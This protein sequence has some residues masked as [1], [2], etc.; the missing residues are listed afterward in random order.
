M[1]RT[2][3]GSKYDLRINPIYQVDWQNEASGKRVSATKRRVRWR[4]GFSNRDALDRGLTGPEA[5]GEEHEVVLVW[6]LASGKRLVIV[7]GQE[8]HFSTGRRT[9]SKFETSWSMFGGHIFQIIAHATLPLFN[10]PSYRQ[11]DLLVDGMSFHAFPKIFQ[12]G[13]RSAPPNATQRTSYRQSPSRSIP[14]VHD[15]VRASPASNVPEMPRYQLTKPIGS[16]VRTQSPPAF[17][18]LLSGPTTPSDRKDLLW[19]SAPQ[20]M[21]D[22]RQKVHLQQKTHYTYQQQQGEFCSSQQQQ[23][24][25][26]QLSPRGVVDEFAPVSP[27]PR[28]FQDVSKEILSA[29]MPDSSIPA[30]TYTPH[31]SEQAY[32]SHSGLATTEEKDNTVSPDKQ[33]KPVIK[34]TMERLSIVEMEE[35]DQPLLSPTEQAVR[36]LVN[37]NDITETLETPEQAKALRRKDQQRPPKSKPLPPATPQWQL[38]LHPALSEIKQYSQ[39]KAEPKKEIMRTHAFDPAA[40]QAGMMMIYGASI[41]PSS[42]FGAGV[43]QTHSYTNVSRVQQ[44]QRMY[45]AY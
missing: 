31:Y 10:E 17:E 19:D 5:R 3:Q 42:G 44:Q 22:Y 45:T 33:Q 26:Q 25:P 1:C 36:T 2:S 6:S 30:L 9:D 14:T 32:Q 8:V 4:F 24:Y 41:P 7:D 38:G 11:F 18:D 34:P 37:L 21:L 12:L 20:S 23:H 40:A 39:A 43:L 13:A 27:P 35:R 16:E 28:T 29:Y 15:I